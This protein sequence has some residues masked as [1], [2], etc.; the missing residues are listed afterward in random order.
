MQS[1]HEAVLVVE[2][3]AT[4]QLAIRA[5]LERFGVQADCVANG[6]QA[7]AAIQA[8]RYG[9]VLMDL[10]MPGM[11]GFA[12]TRQI[13]RLEYGT[14][15]HTPIV[16]VTA[17]D[18]AISRSECIA[19]GMD[20]FVA[21]PI[22][23]ES[24]EEMLKKW[25]AP[26][27]TGALREAG[28]RNAARVLESFLAV[29]AQLLED[30]SAAIESKDLSA[31]T[32]LAHEVKASSLMVSAGEVAQQARRLEQAIRDE[33]WGELV[34]DYRDLVA[35]FRRTTEALKNPF[36]V[37]LEHHNHPGRPAHRP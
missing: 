36:Q 14:G 21:K 3:N 1:G 32:H 30:L 10:M 31:A 24:L 37:I 9:L 16:A 34:D 12:A 8:K 4:N 23:P 28:A 13:R 20:G 15:R 35:A 7:I 18:P 33:K 25:L 27:T 26:S 6:V 17:V 19:A 22:E 2:D 29:T 11:D 5:L